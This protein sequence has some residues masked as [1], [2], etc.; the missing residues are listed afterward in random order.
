MSS[1][2]GTYGQV[3]DNIPVDHHLLTHVAPDCANWLRDNDIRRLDITNEVIQ[4]A[5]QIKNDL[6][7][8]NDDYHADG[9]DEND[10]LIIAT[11]KVEGAVLVSDEKRQTSLPNNIKRFRIP[12]VCA[13][14][15]VAISC[16]NFIDYIK[17][18]SRVFG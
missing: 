8:R 10:L 18:S 2:H 4:N 5:M 13:M 1:F 12:A 17:Q 3:V 7:V 9:V 15:G 6:G 11:A 14:P 16:I